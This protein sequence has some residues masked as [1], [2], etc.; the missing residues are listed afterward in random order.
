MKN[1]VGAILGVAVGTM[2]LPAM[3]GAANPGYG[4]PY[5]LV[6]FLFFGGELLLASIGGLTSPA[7]LPQYLLV[8]IVI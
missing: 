2:L 1:M 6:W 8:W 4:N 5:D 7:T 3:L